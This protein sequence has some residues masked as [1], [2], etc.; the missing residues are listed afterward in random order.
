M[1]IVSYEAR[2]IQS[3]LLSWWE[4]SCIAHC[5]MW[6]SV[7]F[8]S[9]KCHLS[10]WHKLTVLR[11]KHCP[12][13]RCAELNSKDDFLNLHN[14]WPTK[15][16]YSPSATETA[17]DSHIHPLSLSLLGIPYLCRGAHRNT[18]SSKQNK[19]NK[20]LISLLQLIL[21]PYR[22]IYVCRYMSALLRDRNI[23]GDLDH[24]KK[25]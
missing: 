9:Q 3:F 13:Q 12:H 21:K 7:K 19:K 16:T 22:Q 11:Y 2:N 5:L 25:F 6:S 8:I 17:W 20:K 23:L 10:G 15:S 14:W 24:W 1:L 4:G 18:S